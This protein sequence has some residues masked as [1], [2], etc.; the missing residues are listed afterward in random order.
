[1]AHFD[2]LVARMAEQNTAI[3]E[4]KVAADV[5]AILAE[6]DGCCGLASTGR[7]TARG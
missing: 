6:L 3:S 5:N 7:R 1:M 4:E 2:Q